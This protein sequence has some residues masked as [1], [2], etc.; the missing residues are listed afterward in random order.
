MLRRTE[1]EKNS[2]SFEENPAPQNLTGE[3]RKKKEERGVKRDSVK[4][5]L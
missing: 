1:A 3:R 5:K 2:K 4:V